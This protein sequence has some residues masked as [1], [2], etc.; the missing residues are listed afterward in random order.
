[1][2]NA[3]SV[4]RALGLEFRFVWPRTAKWGFSEP[5]DLF[6]DDFLAQFEIAESALEGRI[7]LSDLTRLSLADARELCLEPDA[8]SVVYVDECFNIVAF[9]GEPE[10]SAA[11]R[12]RAVLDEIVWSPTGRG[13]VGLLASDKCPQDY[14]ALHIRAGDIVDGVWCQFVPPEKYIPTP[15]VEFA[16]E[17]LS[18]SRRDPVWVLSDNEPYVRYLKNRFGQIRLSS[19]FFPGYADLT[20]MQR[21]LADS[22]ALSG[23]Q[24]IVGPKLSAFSRLGS[25]LGGVSVESIEDLTTE[26]NAKRLLRDGIARVEKEAEKTEILRPLLV[27][28]ICWYHDVFFDDLSI[29]E[30]IGLAQ[31]ATELEPDFCGALNRLAAALA[32]AG[33]YAESASVSAPALDVAAKIERH[34]DPLVESVA[35]SISADVLA[36]SAAPHRVQGLLARLGNNP[37]VGPLWRDDAC[38][39]E[40]QELEQKLAQCESLMPFQLHHPDVV[41]NLRFQIA[42]A[43]WLSIARYRLHR[44]V[45]ETIKATVNGPPFLSAWRPSGLHELAKGGMFPQVLRNTEV[46]TVHLAQ[47]IGAALS[48]VSPRRPQ[49]GCLDRV[50]ASP[51]GLQWVYGWAYNVKTRRS[52]YAIGYLH[53]N[54][55]VSGGTVG[56][57][58][59]DV[60][61]ALND[62]R[63]LHSGF[64]F[65]VPLAVQDVGDIDSN[66]RVL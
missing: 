12:F 31:R 6:D 60:V 61:E 10:V 66:T 48:R 37:W 56:L 42:V 14:S 50:V 63:A 3:L 13:L 17:K 59:P 54:E 58:R 49:I 21:A 34:A 62:P 1:M 9:A 35:T 20:E 47:A 23:A 32:L 4:A 15:Y 52:P 26:A 33:R 41:W 22:L 57:E 53:N 27:R 40:L 2:L 44:V 30:R 18:G 51:S 43:S 24:R 45:N 39:G 65:P 29:D 19:D 28:D 46:T 7:A 5:R 64:V 16:I 38:D 55:I 11:G 36:Y 8:N 25:L